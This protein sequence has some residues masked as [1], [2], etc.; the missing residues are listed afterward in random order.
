MWF[1]TWE[2]PADRYRRIGVHMWKLGRVPSLLCYTEDTESVSWASP[3]T[4]SQTPALLVFTVSV[5]RNCRLLSSAW[6]GAVTESFTKADIHL[7]TIYKLRRYCSVSALSFEQHG[8]IQHQGDSL[9]PAICLWHEAVNA[10]LVL[11]DERRWRETRWESFTAPVENNTDN[12]ET[13]L[14]SHLFRYTK[15]HPLCMREEPNLN[16]SAPQ[17]SDRQAYLQLCT[18]MLYVRIIM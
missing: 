1:L 18:V 12:L 7:P 16:L 9:N 10:A 2:I 11:V 5:Y 6:K 13:K 8:S 17:K 3:G 14:G 4:C 15:P